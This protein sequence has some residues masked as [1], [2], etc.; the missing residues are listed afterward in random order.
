MKTAFLALMASACLMTACSPM[1]ANRGN[2]LDTYQM[3]EILP[4]VDNRDSLTAKIGSPTT[5]APFD[6]N[7]WYYIGQK[8]EKNGIMDPRITEER[9]VVVT[10]AEDGMVDKVM[11][12]AD[13]REDI[14]IV[15]RKTPTTGNE[16]TFVQ[17][18]LGNLGKFNR[19]KENSATT[20]GGANNR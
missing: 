11:E 5:I 2:M 10:F 14:P 15:Q 16:Y 19:A 1:T 17:Q 8:T 3:K 18:M 9:I 4:G 12:R 20:A 13:G 6:N 7:T